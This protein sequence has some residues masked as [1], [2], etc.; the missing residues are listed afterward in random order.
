MA[1]MSAQKHTIGRKNTIIIC[2][3]LEF[4]IRF[5]QFIKKLANSA[6]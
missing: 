4:I 5:G 6:D 1:A 3:G 2:L